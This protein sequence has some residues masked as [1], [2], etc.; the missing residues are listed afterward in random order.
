MLHKKDYVIHKNKF[1]LGF[2]ETVNKELYEVN[3]LNYGLKKISN[4]FSGS[5]QF[6]IKADKSMI[7][8][9]LS[10]KYNSINKFLLQKGKDYFKK[11]KVFD[12]TFD[13]NSLSSVV[14]GNYDY[15]VHIEFKNNSIN[16]YNCTCPVDGFC[17]HAVATLF[18]ANHC[19]N[20]INKKQSIQ[21]IIQL[22]LENV[23]KLNVNFNYDVTS[24]YDFYLAYLDFKNNY[25]DKLYAYLNALEAYANED[26]EI[27]D[28]ILSFLLLYEDST[29]K[30]INYCEKIT[31]SNTLKRTCRYVNNRIKDDYNSRYSWYHR[32]S[33]ITFKELI[34]NE[35]YTQLI[36]EIIHTVYRDITNFLI[37]ADIPKKYNLLENFKNIFKK[38]PITDLAIKYLQENLDK[39]QFTQYLST[40]NT[41]SLSANLLVE[42]LSEEQL[43]NAAYITRDKKIVE[44]ICNHYDDFLKINKKKTIQTI[45]YNYKDYSRK[46][47][48]KVYKIIKELK[49]PYLYLYPT[50]DFESLENK[51]DVDVNLINEYFD[52]K[53]DFNETQNDL[54]VERKITLDNKIL[55]L[56]SEEVFRGRYRCDSFSPDNIRKINNILEYGLILTYGEQYQ[57]DLNQK[58]EEI[59]L[60]RQ[61]MFEQQFN[62]DIVRFNNALL[63]E[64]IM[65]SKD[66]LMD[67]EFTFKREYENFS[68]SLRVG[69][70]KKYIVK[71]VFDFRRDIIRGDFVEYGKG[72][73]FSHHID[74][75]KP[76]YKKPLEYA[77]NLIDENCKNREIIFSGYYFSKL[78]FLLKGL[79]VKYFNNEYLVRLNKIDYNVKVNSDYVVNDNF[80]GKL[81]IIAYDHSF[82][83]NKDEGVIDIITD[84][85]NDTEFVNFIY[86]YN[87]ICIKNILSA[88]NEIIYQRFN[89]MIEVDDTLKENFKIKDVIIKAHFDY[90]NKKITLKTSLYDEDNNLINEKQITENNYFKLKKYLNYISN[91][92]FVDN[93]LID[94][95]KILNFFSMDFT[96]LKK[97]CSVYLSETITNKKIEIFNKHTIII[98]N[99]STVMEAFVENS[100]YSDDELYE[101]LKA[102]KLKKKFV[103]LKGDRIVRLDSNDAEEFY[104]AVNALKLDK[105]NVLKPKCIPIYQSIKAQAS[106]NNIKLDDYLTNMI[107]ELAN[108]KEYETPMPHLNTTLREYQ[109]EGFKWLTILT[110]YHLGGIL[111]DDMGLGKTIQMIAL[112][113]M[114]KNNKPSLIVCP[115]T[116]I[117]NWKNE[118][119][120]F[121]EEAKVIEIYGMANVRERIIKEIDYNSNN[122]YLTSYDSLRND[123]ELY[124]QE[125]NFLILD[126][127]QVIK[128]VYAAKSVAVK[129]IKAINRFALTGTP[130]ENNI[131]DLWSIFDFIMPDYFEELSEFKSLYNN[132]EDFTN[133]VALKVSP[134]ILRRTK[135]DV[136]NDL[137]NKYEQIITV[138]MNDDQRKIY[139]AYV[140]EAQNVLSI[141]KKSFD[142]FPY[143]MKLRQICIDPTLF[144]ENYD[145][146]S[147]KMHALKE[148][149]NEYIAGGHKLLIFSQFVKALDIVK[150]Y[151]NAQN[152]K[153]FYLTGETN[154]LDRIKYTEEF[155]AN[156][157]IKI[158]LIS[159]KAGGTGL[160]LIGADT[161]IHLDPWWNQAVEDQATDRSYRIG[162]NKNVEVIKLIC[163]DSIEQRVIELQNLKKDLID[164]LISNDDSSIT[165]LSFD[166]LKF[167]LKN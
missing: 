150:K 113:Q 149:I 89:H 28:F 110:K 114:Q 140:L 151:L 80:K 131:I 120:K 162:Q 158:F 123:L 42:L 37:K 18:E 53:Y 134:F 117:F 136:L 21:N 142:I 103:L 50:D 25:K 8:Y 24:L 31:T 41:G 106:L 147:A 96:E 87:D 3:F 36:E 95:N 11:R 74:N 14:S 101:I 51:K 60:K 139:D 143:L 13:Q 73:A 77:L 126:E 52:F 105:K 38:Y 115:K 108:F 40:I 68:L 112:L 102:I 161:V 153:H 49:N 72:L 135:K 75:F 20:Q 81:L 27:Y 46:L 156:N 44:Y 32:T 86:H 152:I 65:L 133:K 63:S 104:D 34:I 16:S 128:N 90:N 165:R 30:T 35:N 118:F 92:G 99:K 7:D 144:V 160:N 15:N 19:L 71:N 85:K 64:P 69:N 48:D 33:D 88:F 9:L 26:V 67:V 70:E 2:I 4:S 79:K 167:I 59:K 78:L 93:E 146:S 121:D 94:A 29:S 6:L 122:I 109:I 17:K 155:N 58:I 148:I 84:N 55:I 116:L 119:Q 154:A 138:S 129:N 76:I 56:I 166:D 107:N 111:A 159:L 97:L 23:E 145:G 47:S 132:D 54:I 5:S 12:L 66:H 45:I 82:Y 164:K 83:C 1:G 22:D 39:E 127:A 130:V 57:N 137:P 141:G 62:N 163:E 91:L 61:K 100:N 10:E 98:N 124:Q 125:F 43:L 157:E